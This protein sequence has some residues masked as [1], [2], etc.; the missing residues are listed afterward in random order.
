MNKQDT[1][2]LKEGGV[3]LLTLG[4]IELAKSVFKSTIDYGTV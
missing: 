1:D 3:R 4:E 2:T